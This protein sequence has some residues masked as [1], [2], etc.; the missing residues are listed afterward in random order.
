M[1]N[2][3]G[4]ELK[5]GLKVMFMRAITLMVTKKVMEHLN[6]LMVLLIQVHS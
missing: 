5:P 2:K 1:T 4:K 6:G 3:M